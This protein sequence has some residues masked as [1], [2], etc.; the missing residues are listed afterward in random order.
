M[1]FSAYL[2]LFGSLVVGSGGHVLCCAGQGWKHFTVL[3]FW[4]LYCLFAQEKQ[5]NKK[6]RKKTLERGLVRLR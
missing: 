6:P 1:V 4:P 2:I 5:T 3:Y